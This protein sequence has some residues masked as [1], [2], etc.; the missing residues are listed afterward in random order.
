MNPRE[1][2]LFSFNDLPLI[3]PWLNQETFRELRAAG[4][5]TPRV[6]R[7]G[8]DPEKNIPFMDVYDLVALTAIQQLLRS[9]VSADQ[10][11]GPSMLR[12]TTVAKGCPRTTLFS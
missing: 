4:L 5:F 2:D 11:R 8:T 3:A 12:R 6:V 7:K 10:L 9:V 1:D